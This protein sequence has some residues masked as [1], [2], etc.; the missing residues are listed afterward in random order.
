MAHMKNVLWKFSDYSM[1]HN[2]IFYDVYHI[3]KGS[4]S[5]KLLYFRDHAFSSKYR[6]KNPISPSGNCMTDSQHTAACSW[7]ML[8]Y[9]NLYNHLEEI[10]CKDTISTEKV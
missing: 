10:F 8:V 9:N 5:K 6:K 7:E 4:F 3:H 2:A 1:R